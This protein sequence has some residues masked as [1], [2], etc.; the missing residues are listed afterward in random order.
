MTAAHGIGLFFLG[1]TLTFLGFLIAWIVYEKYIQSIKNAR[2]E[3][4]RSFPYDF[5]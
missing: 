5:R 1:T 3:K 4:E 2:E